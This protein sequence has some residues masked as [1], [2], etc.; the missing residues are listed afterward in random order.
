VTQDD[1]DAQEDGTPGSSLPTGTLTFLRSDIEGSMELVRALGPRYDELNEAHRAIVRAAVDEHDGQVV[2]TEGDA[3]FSVFTDAAAAARAAVEMQRGLAAHP[4]PDGHP[5]RVRVGLHAGTAYRAGDDYGGFEV[6]RAARVA[7]MG[8]GGQIVL[9]EP[10]RA[11]IEDGLPD[12]WSMRDL[13]RYRLKGIAEPE[14]LHQ[15][16]APGLPS[17]F[18][19]LRNPTGGLERLPARLT[20]LV[21]REAELEALTRLLSGTRLLT[22]TGPGGTGKTTLA[23]ELARREAAAFDDG[24]RFVD[25]QSVREAEAVRAEVAHAL[26]LLDGPT[27]RAAD[28]LAAYLAERQLL[29]V[30]DNFEQVMEAA[31]VIPELLRASPRSSL[32]VTSRI[33][34]R[35][36]AEQEYAVR[37]L[38]LESVP[39]DGMPEAMRLFLERARRVRP[40]LVVGD[41][42][43]AAI[44][45]ICRLVDG[46]P[47]AIELC[48]ARAGALPVRLIHDRLSAHL[49]LP[50]SGP[51]DLPA[52]QRTIEDTVAWSHELLS[53]A[54]QR[55][56]ARLAVF[57]ETFDLEQAEQVCGPTV[58]LGV[59]VL[60]GLVTLVE[61]SLL[62]RV[63]DQVGGVRFRMLETIRNWAM[64]RL[65]ASGEAATLRDRH[66]ASFAALVDRAAPHLPGSQ[67]A[68][69][70]DRLG[71]DDANLRT[72]TRHAIDSGAV[73][74]AL[75][76][77]AGLW[78]YWLQT[79]RLAEGRELVAAALALPGSEA[80]TRMRVR[81]LDAA[82]G[83]AYWSGEVARADAIYE[84][85]LALAQ[86]LGDVEGE[87]L[88][89][90]DL[91]F[92]REFLGDD[93][94]AGKA[95]EMAGSIYRRLG[96]RVGL[97]RVEMSWSIMAF[98]RGGVDPTMVEELEAMADRLDQ[99]PD[100]WVRREAP[101]LRALVSWVRGDVRVA[102]RWLV[103][104]VRMSLLHRE[105][106]DA[107]LATQFFVVAALPL[108][109][110]EIGT[111]VHGAL[112]T[113]LEQLG[114]RPP[115]SYVELSGSDPIPVLR[116]TLGRERF[117]AALER[118]RRM[119]LEEAI[120]LI[121][122]AVG[123]LGSPG[124]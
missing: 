114:I 62:T 100:P 122:A 24:A 90:L 64:S 19:P 115:A 94:G 56:L 16:E 53:A 4:W 2:R 48:A 5:I 120:D 113:A 45:D 36:S 101:A 54:H 52:R 11:L 78:R 106:G 84:E 111:I 25:L 32:I 99:E 102:A 92:T 107:A 82:G 96:D 30:I 22:L 13:G 81:A 93:Q 20:S 47:L 55:L 60:D 97:A 34:L 17:A 7:S 83:V 41:V 65:E 18:P 98:A 72:A 44:R 119:S 69:W 15:L 89:W 43:E 42:D 21:G 26:G 77:V 80:P 73:E 12:G 70:A 121:D 33:P 117:E 28:R 29:I 88:A 110:P 123:S 6:N 50:G 10:A 104:G 87:A 38:A 31:G 1:P 112:Q 68:Y 51:R 37:P 39:G 91:Y 8:W 40:D 108:D 116:E 66:A 86:Q 61:Q 63:D 95:R 3:F 85:E 76:S 103:T 57:E 109:L 35:L 14:R 9:S 75:R 58:E 79:G 105:R 74:V 67:Q 59:D 46:L 124:P 71:A 27:G 23:L 118:G 49:P